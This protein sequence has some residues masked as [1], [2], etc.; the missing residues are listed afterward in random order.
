MLLVAFQH[1]NYLHIINQDHDDRQ[2]VMNVQWG[3]AHCAI[4]AQILTASAK[5]E[6]HK[7]SPNVST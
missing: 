5:G 6:G 3:T 4:D 7:K 2:K 1:Q